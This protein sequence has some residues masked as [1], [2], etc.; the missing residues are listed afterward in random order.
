MKRLLRSRLFWIIAIPLV[1]LVMCTPDDE[2]RLQTPPSTPAE[3][4]PSTEAHA[5]PSQHVDVRS[6]LGVALGLETRDR[7]R[8]GYKRA[9]FGPAWQDVDHNGC[10]TRN[11]VLRRE[12]RK[13]Q[14]KPGTKG[15]VLLKGRL[16]DVDY[17][18]YAQREVLYTRGDGKIE[19]DHVVPLADAWRAGAYA[20]EPARR[21]QFANDAENL[22]AIDSQSNQAKGDKTI[23]KWKPKDEEEACY[24]AARQASV[25]KRYGL[26]VTPLERTMMLAILDS[27]VCGGRNFAP[28]KPSHYKWPKP[29]PMGE[30]KPKPQPE[31]QPKPQP[32]QTYYD[33]CSAVR[34]AGADP[35]HRGDPGYGRHLDRDGDG[36]ACE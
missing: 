25:K 30:P 7:D 20:W 22:E 23:N 16:A 12:L 36:V 15:C 27:E 18:N 14:T 2:P 8:V 24:Y 35:I 17:E 21:L 3:P 9:A 13:R 19:I 11:D 31:P 5:S 26:T 32:D 29:K 1:L 6:A 10:D 28:E 34:A 33:N 4:V